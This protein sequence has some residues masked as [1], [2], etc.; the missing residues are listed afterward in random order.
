L[1][2]GEFSSSSGGYKLLFGRENYISVVTIA[3]TGTDTVPLITD[4]T[5]EI[6]A[7]GQNVAV[8]GI[9]STDNVL[10]LQS[11]SHKINLCDITDLI[12]CF[13]S[14]VVFYQESSPGIEDTTIEL[15]GIYPLLG[16]G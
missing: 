11:G 16:G 7:S 12:G 13:T 15:L 14:P 4:S 9:N 10:Y 3:D 1:G 5:E 6:I 2:F 8:V